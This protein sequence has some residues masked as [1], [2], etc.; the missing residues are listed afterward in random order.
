MLFSSRHQILQVSFTLSGRVSQCCPLSEISSHYFLHQATPTQL[1]PVATNQWLIRDRLGGA[2]FTSVN[3]A[4]AMKDPPPLVGGARV[5][6][7]F[8]L[9]SS[10]P[11]TSD[12]QNLPPV[13]TMAV[14]QCSSRT[15]VVVVAWQRQSLVP[16]LLRKDVAS[17]KALLSGT[18]KGEPLPR[19]LS[20]S[21]SSCPRPCRGAG[22]TL[23]GTHL[24]RLQHST[25]AVPPRAA[26][27][28]ITLSFPPW[29]GPAEHGRQDYS[30]RRRP[31]RDHEAG[32]GS[33]QRLGPSPQ[34]G[35]AL[36]GKHAPLQY[37][38]NF[39]SPRPP[40]PCP[41]GQ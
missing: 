24:W 10:L 33:G 4:S 17:L 15:N 18:A 7:G 22:D 11:L 27:G 25:R 38:S 14:G 9:T 13:T 40:R 6:Q 20:S 26:S 34:L 39:L 28:A 41:L 16:V 8:I 5:K 30:P 29:G 21:P 37:V 31:Q 3:A 32:H 1:L 2:H 12:P 19:T 36:I 35:W 23:I